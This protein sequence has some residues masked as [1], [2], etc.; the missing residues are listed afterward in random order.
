MNEC[1]DREPPSALALGDAAF[2][3]G[4]PESYAEISMA[5][6]MASRFLKRK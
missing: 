1:R 4:L 2:K 5:C 3:L 6:S